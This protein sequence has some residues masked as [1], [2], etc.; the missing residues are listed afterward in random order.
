M[1]LGIN[2]HGIVD[3]RDRERVTIC[4]PHRN[5]G[6]PVDIEIPEPFLRHNRFETGDIVDGRTEPLAAAEA[7]NEA[8]DPRIRDGGNGTGAAHHRDVREIPSERL[9][10]LA[11]INGLPLGE[12]ENR[13][14]PRESRNIYERVRPGR[15]LRLAAGS[16]ESTGRSM[17]FAAPL[18]MGSAGIIHGPHGSGLSRALHQVV[19]GVHANAPDIL[20]IVLLLRPR[21][22]EVTFW[23]RSFPGVD[24]VVC[25]SGQADATPEQALRAADLVLEAGLRQTEL[26][27]HVLLAV[28]SLT[29]LWAAMLEAEGADAQRE[30][31]I[32]VA[33]HRIRQWLQKAGD[34]S[35]EGFLGS[36]L[37]GSLSLVGTTWTRDF[38][39]EAEEEG[40]IHPHLRL[41]EHL[42]PES[43]WQIALSDELAADRLF[44]AID[45]S[46]CLS[47][48][49]ENLVDA[50]MFDRL[51]AARRALLEI[52]LRKQHSTWMD[53]LAETSDM[54][55]LLERL[56]GKGATSGSSF[57]A[58]RN[59]LGGDETQNGA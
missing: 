22:E 19:K 18:G 11:S 29:G 17:D 48:D 46:R 25:P 35:G 37:G 1:P 2:E 34:F 33:R 9:I 54:D 24:V 21:G 51:V 3:A 44:P 13:P 4:R 6:V 12:A 7:M 47:R 41:L 32:A 5:G 38:D 30:A 36:G 57:E 23:R 20:P 45:L 52:P 39:I 43:N 10:S 50:G 8:A 49:E 26:G 14:S 42:L 53:A 28:D 16:E 55:S 40:E 58:L 59:L 31:D 27:R 56:G 15:L